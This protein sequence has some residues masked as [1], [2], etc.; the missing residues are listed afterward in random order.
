M[1]DLV[2]TE[3]LLNEMVLNCEISASEEEFLGK[4][5]LGKGDNTKLTKGGKTHDASST[6]LRNNSGGQDRICL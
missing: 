4:E 6:R 5:F 1:E 3:Q 2:I